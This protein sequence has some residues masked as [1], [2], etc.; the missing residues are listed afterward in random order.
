M[1]A[2]SCVVVECLPHGS[3]SF[4]CSTADVFSPD[5][6]TISCTDAA[7]DRVHGPL[8]VFPPGSWSNATVFD[9]HG[10]VQYL[11]SSAYQRENE[12]R[13]QAALAACRERKSA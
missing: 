7:F 6:L 12:V 5:E 3:S 8:R 11:L 4:A 1:N 2:L 9:E 13:F 10:N